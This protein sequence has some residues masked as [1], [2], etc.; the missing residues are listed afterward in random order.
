M[1]KGDT[2]KV[3]FTGVVEEVR[4]HGSAT[5]MTMGIRH[6]VRSKDSGYAHMIFEGAGN[7]Y[8]V[9][10]TDPKHWPPQ[11]GDVWKAEDKT[12]M[13]RGDK[14]GVYLYNIRLGTGSEDPKAVMIGNPDLRLVYRNF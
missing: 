1:K 10:K 2:I 9:V 8:E 11:P 14:G 13:A 5:D 7:D 12:W 6:V 3:S 4:P